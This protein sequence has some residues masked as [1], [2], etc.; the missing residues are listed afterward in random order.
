MGDGLESVRGSSTCQQVRI[1]Q[2][3][4]SRRELL[5]L[6]ARYCAEEIL[7]T[8]PV[9]LPIGLKG[10]PLT[11]QEEMKIMLRQEMLKQTSE[12]AGVHFEV[13]PDGFDIFEL[14]PDGE[15]DFRSEYELKEMEPEFPVGDAPT[16]EPENDEGVSP[17]P[18]PAGDDNQESHT[19]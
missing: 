3:N 16:P 17:S 4:L 12:Q 6:A 13:V 11:L 5:R 7:D 1:R 14:D 19:A 15:P 2:D 10:R 9:E 8:T 18:A